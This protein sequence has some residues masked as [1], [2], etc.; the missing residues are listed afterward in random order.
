MKQKFARI[1]LS[2]EMFSCALNNINGKAISG[3]KCVSLCCVCSYKIRKKHML[4]HKGYNWMINK[5]W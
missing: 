3:M 4:L 2:L 5:K 1:S